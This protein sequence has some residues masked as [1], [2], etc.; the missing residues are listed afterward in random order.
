MLRL[1]RAV[2]IGWLA[3]VACFAHAAIVDVDADIIWNDADAQSKCPKLCIDKHL[4]WTGQW[5]KVGW[6]ET[7]VCSCDDRPPPKP[8]R[9]PDFRPPPMPDREIDSRPPPPDRAGLSV[10][11]YESTN[12][13]D[14]DLRNAPAYSYERCADMCLAA[15]DCRAF[16]FAIDQ[17][18]CYLK[19]GSSRPDRSGTAIS[20]I[21]VDSGGYNPEADSYHAPPQGNGPSCSINSTPKCPG[22][23]VT[24]SP[25]QNAV[26]EQAVEGVTSFCARNASCKCS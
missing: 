8:D 9:E 3:L 25:G 20:G 6:A 26:C 10:R 1:I 14:N 4:Y 24:C 2:A 5:R 7:P 13:P 16:T 17:R 23:S 21:V 22:C 18:R 11:R 15:S 12:F 19:S